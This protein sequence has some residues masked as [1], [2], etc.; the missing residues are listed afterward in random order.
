MKKFFL[1]IALGFASLMVGTIAVNAKGVSTFANTITSGGNWVHYKQKEATST[2]NGIREYWVACGLNQYQFTA[3]DSKNIREATSYDTSGF[4]ENDPRW[5]KWINEDSL[6][7][8][9]SSVGNVDCSEINQIDGNCKVF[10]NFNFEIG[11]KTRINIAKDNDSP[12]Y[13]VMALAVSKA[14]DSNEDLSSFAKSIEAK[15]DDG[16]YVITADLDSPTAFVNTLASECYFSGTIDGRNHTISNPIA[17]GNRL[18]GQVKGATIKNLN[19]KDVSVFSIL[20]SSIKDT[21]IENCSFK[22]ASALNPASGVGF[23][24]DAMYSGVCLKDVTIDFGGASS[25]ISWNDSL[26]PAIAKENAST[27]ENPVTYENVVFHGLNSTDMYLKDTQGRALRPDGITYESSYPFLENGASSYS[28]AYL[29]SSAEAKTAASYVQG[30]LAASTGVTL[31]LISFEQASVDEDHKRAYI[32]FGD[33]TLAPSYGTS[34]PDAKG[35]FTLFTGGKGIFLF[36]ADTMGY[37]AGALKLLEELVG[38]RYVG[39][40]TESFTYTKG[41]SI[42]LPYLRL[43]YTPSFG[44]RKCDWSDGSDGDMYSWGYNQ[45]Y[46]DYS[47]YIPAPAVGTLSGE[48]FHTSI[49]ALYPGT[50]YAD[51]PS[52]FA[53]SESGGNYG[54]NYLLW[55]L[56]YTAHGN[57]DEYQAMVNQA[58]T[59]VMWL[60]NTRTNKNVKT[61]LF[62]IADNG[63]ICHCSACNAGVAKYGSIAGTVLNFVN[64]LRDLV[65]PQLDEAEQKEASIGFFAYGGYEEAPIINDAPTIQMK[66]NVFCLVAPINANFTYPLTDSCNASSKAMF[67]DWTRIGDVS[68]WLYDTNFMYYLFPLNCFEANHD[69]LVYLKSKGVKMVY[70]QGQHTATQPRTAFGAFKKFLAGR[71]MMDVNQSYASLKNE[72]F[73]SYYGEAGGLMEQFFDE[74]VSRCVSIETNSKFHDDLYN[75]ETSYG[76]TVFEQIANGNFWDFHETKSWADLCDTAYTMATSSSAKR[77]IKIESVF[78]RMA[79]CELWKAVKWGLFDGSSKLKAFRQ[80]FKADCEELGITTYRESG[81]QLS[82]FYEQWGIA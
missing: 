5:I 27:L 62:G 44:L 80:S 47:Y 16:Y 43:S 3:P 82:Y 52:W 34:V 36:S 17:W 33:S 51:H 12:I 71:T 35:S 26:V 63:N 31:P 42:D 39:D 78:P 55:Q 45:G 14:I 10:G 50:Y 13:S 68:A 24:C 29:S 76:K 11:C 67:D 66:N 49:R 72:F 37:Q 65:I 6:A 64:D 48:Y 69:N 25:K 74:M 23:L 4:V 61:F 46:G 9:D 22:A 73:S 20:A 18:L 8:Y 7:F 59:Y 2:E 28:L 15:N 77:H 70:L 21:M 1:F 30:K 32:Y 19:Y 60:Y 41:T 40:Q 79:L 58:A 54:D 75:L 81:V 57:S 53:E 56:C 38:Y